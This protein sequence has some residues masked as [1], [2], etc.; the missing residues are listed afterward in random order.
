M[1]F[2]CSYQQVFIEHLLST[3]KSGGG[4]DGIQQR[5]FDRSASPLFFFSSLFQLKTETKEYLSIAWPQNRE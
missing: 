2:F 1:K 5:N 3:G 4:Y